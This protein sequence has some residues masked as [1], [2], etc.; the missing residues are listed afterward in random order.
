MQKTML[1]I[2]EETVEFY[3]NNPRS[4]GRGK[5]CSYLTDDGRQCAFSRC[6]TDEGV[7]KLQEGT[8]VVYEYLDYLKPE[9]QGYNLFFWVNIQRLHDNNNFWKESGDKNILTTDGIDYVNELKI[10]YCR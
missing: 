8:R 4:I 10:I 1:Q 7:K 5:S 3:Q 6:C 9:Y 2:V